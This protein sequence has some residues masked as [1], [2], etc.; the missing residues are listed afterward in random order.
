M[1]EII[2]QLS[3]IICY[4]KKKTINDETYIHGHQVVINEHL[5]GLGQSIEHGAED[6]LIES[7]KSDEHDD[8]RLLVR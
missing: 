3:L 5:E 2:Y 6:F 1:K 4:N 8:G 7:I